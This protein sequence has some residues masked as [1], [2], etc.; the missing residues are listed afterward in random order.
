MNEVVGIDTIISG[1][2]YVSS[3][4]FVNKYFDSGILFKGYVIGY[5]YVELTYKSVPPSDLNGW[6]GRKREVSHEFDY[7]DISSKME[8]D[9]SLDAIKKSLKGLF[10]DGQTTITVKAGMTLTGIASLFDVTVDEL[11]RWNDIENPD[12]I[13]V[14]QKIIVKS[15]GSIQQANSLPQETGSGVCGSCLDPATIGGNLLGL[16][17]PGGNNPRSYDGDTCYIYVPIN[18]AEYPAIGHD[19]RYDRLKI[20]GAGGLFFNTKAI[21]ADW[22]FVAEELFIYASTSSLE[23]SDSKLSALLLGVGLGLA[24]TPKT[25]YQLFIKRMGIFNMLGFYINVGE[26]ISDYLES[27]H[28]VTNTPT[29][30]MHK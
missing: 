17:Y 25:Y 16:S 7:F 21:G 6:R 14:G 20:E 4:V 27:N 19:R 2:H 26:V 23:D 29:I 18:K 30:H 15:N 5:G 9:R 3:D 28:G 22:R 13:V 11:V 8:S 1:M 10:V 24:A 12:K